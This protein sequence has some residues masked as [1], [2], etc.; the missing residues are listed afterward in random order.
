VRARREDLEPREGGRDEVLLVE[1]GDEDGEG[2]HGPGSSR[3]YAEFPMR[4][5]APS[6]CS[7]QRS[8]DRS[9]VGMAESGPCRTTIRYASAPSSG[10]HERNE[11]PS[12]AAR[13]RSKP[14]ILSKNTDRFVGLVAVTTSIGRAATTSNG[15]G[16]GSHRMR[17]LE[18]AS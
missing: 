11:L 6:L 13:M 7:R 10:S 15:S 12:R 9:P 1:D 3:R 4:N 8:I 18:P 2:G 14:D 16:E 17:T 5:P